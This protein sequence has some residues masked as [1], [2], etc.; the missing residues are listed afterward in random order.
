LNAKDKL[1]NI[2]EEYTLWLK[3]IKVLILIHPPSQYS[4]N[5]Y[6]RRSFKKQS[7]HWKEIMEYAKIGAPVFDG[8]NYG[9]W[10]IR[11]KTFLQAQGF[12]VW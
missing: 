12:D 1:L 2:V 10:S 4:N 9:F 7:N 8:Q 3:V 6:Q 11:M 5:W